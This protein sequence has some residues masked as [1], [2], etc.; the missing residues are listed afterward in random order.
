MTMLEKY[1]LFEN[2]IKLNY[3]QIY[4]EAWA[5]VENEQYE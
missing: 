2:F 3:E 1:Q 5:H 4:D